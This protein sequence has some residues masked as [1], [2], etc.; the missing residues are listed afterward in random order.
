MSHI[1]RSVHPECKVNVTNTDESFNRQ[2]LRSVDRLQ[3]AV[4]KLAALQT[5]RRLQSCC[6]LSKQFS[7]ETAPPFESGIQ[8]V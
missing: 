1:H 5:N 6:V 8:V 2:D 3:K 7:G 4:R